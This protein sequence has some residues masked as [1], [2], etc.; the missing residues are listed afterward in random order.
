MRKPDLHGMATPD[1]VAPFARITVDQD[2]ALLGNQIARFNRLYG[3]MAE[4][5][6]ELK[7]RDGD[8]RTAL[9]SL[10]EHPNMQ[11]RL[12]A[13]KFKLAVAPVE[14]RRQLEAIASSKWFPQ[15]GDAG[16]CLSFLDDGTF[17][18]K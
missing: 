5:A 3:V 9:L 16:M 8:Q 6:D 10:F 11:V 18:P 15:A 2:D 4:I 7:S 14:A 12:Q 1:L 17:K 13:A